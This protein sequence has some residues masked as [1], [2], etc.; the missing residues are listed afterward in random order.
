MEFKL[1]FVDINRDNLSALKNHFGDVKGVTFQ[2]CDIGQSLLGCEKPRCVADAGQSFG[3]M[4]G[5]RHYV[6]LLY[7]HDRRCNIR[8]SPPIC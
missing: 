8:F 7:R 1:H 6:C 4:D 3:M 5:E 2:H